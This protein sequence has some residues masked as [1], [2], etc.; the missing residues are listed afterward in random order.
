MARLGW[1]KSPSQTPLDFVAAIQEAALQNK[2]ARFTRAYE[3]ARFGKSVDDA[4]S[5][6]GLFQDITAVE[7]VDSIKATNRAGG[8]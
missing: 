7:T 1:R 6:P 4:Q 5:L 3:S 8:S 2:V